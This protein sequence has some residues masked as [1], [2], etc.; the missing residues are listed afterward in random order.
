MVKHLCL[1]D[2]LVT[3]DENDSEEE[4]D[5]AGP[6]PSTLQLGMAKKLNELTSTL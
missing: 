2:I 6:I 5:K 1:Y 4:E 3:V